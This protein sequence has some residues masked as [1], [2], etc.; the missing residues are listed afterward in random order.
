MIPGGMEIMIKK[1][2]FG[3]VLVLTLVSIACADQPVKPDAL[4]GLTIV[5]VGPV[6]DEIYA[7]LSIEFPKVWTNPQFT[8]EINGK[9]A[10][11]RRDPKVSRK[12]A[13]RRIFSSSRER[14]R[15][16]LSL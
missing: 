5:S 14:Q 3:F 9:P 13:T 12:T 10:R 11:M 2:L 7:A 4:R 6:K 16:N 1:L 8:L 15:N